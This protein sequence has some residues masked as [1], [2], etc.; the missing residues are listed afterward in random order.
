MSNSNIK[1]TS[2]I[3]VL[4]LC[5][6]LITVCAGLILGVVYSVTAEPIARQQEII[7]NES[8]KQ[9]LPNA[10]AFVPVDVS[11]VVAD[12]SDFGEIQDV[13]AG[14]D[15]QGTLTGY[16]LAISTKGYSP[17]LELTVGIDT[18]G[19]VQGVDISSH[20]ETP[21]LGANATNTDFLGQFVGADGPLTVVKTATG[22]TG[23]VQA[24]TGA[25]ITSRAVTNAVN[26]ARD[27]FI[28]ILAEGV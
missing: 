16:T 8:R 20:E 7:A 4:V 6:M 28:G 3:G 13:Y 17:N 9:V 25:T 19:V 1:K 26:M 2:S 10:D 15:A 5:L 22:Q 11:G 14:M 27:F 24:L 23:E 21:G 12:G 18:A